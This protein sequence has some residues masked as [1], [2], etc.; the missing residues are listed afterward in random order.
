MSAHKATWEQR[1]ARFW[2]NFDKA[3]PVPEHRPDLGPCWVWK[4]RKNNKGYGLVT[5]HGIGTK[6]AHRTAFEFAH[7]PI[8]TGLEP[9]HLCR[10]RACGRPDH[11]ESVTHRENVRRSE[12]AQRT[13][14]PHGH[15]YTPENT[16]IQPKGSRACRTCRRTHRRK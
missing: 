16:Y 7:G 10:N 6:T 5:W 15:Q 4:L 13:H 1:E 11:M 2:S 3:G 12:P 8:P 9:D 14:C